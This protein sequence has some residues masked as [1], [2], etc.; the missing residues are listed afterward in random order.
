MAIQ[1][2]VE[3]TLKYR[4]DA[5]VYFAITLALLLLVLLFRVNIEHLKFTQAFFSFY[6]NPVGSLV[7]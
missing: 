7:F 3:K 4:W 6:K 5:G 1:H 2:K